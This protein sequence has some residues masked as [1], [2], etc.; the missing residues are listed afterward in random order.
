MVG[1]VASKLPQIAPIK[2][3]S[4]DFQ[5]PQNFCWAGKAE[6]LPGLQGVG[7]ELGIL[8]PSIVVHGAGLMQLISQMCCCFNIGQV[9]ITKYEGCRFTELLLPTTHEDDLG[10][11]RI[12]VCNK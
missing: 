2:T 4:V 3:T 11:L 6:E 5:S 1:H 10:L 9:P 12:Q 8:H 7:D